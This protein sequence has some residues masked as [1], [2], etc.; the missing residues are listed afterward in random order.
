M[1]KEISFSFIV[2]V[3]QLMKFAVAGCSFGTIS[4][5]KSGGMSEVLDI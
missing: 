4:F 1:E 2:G 3:R 5:E